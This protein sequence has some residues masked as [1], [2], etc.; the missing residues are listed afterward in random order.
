MHMGTVNIG[1]TMSLDGFINDRNG[2]V[3]LLY[4][5]WEA[6][7]DAALMQE[8]IANAGAVVMGRH[9]FDMAGDPDSYAV[10][11]EYQ[12]PIFVVTH[13]PPAKHPKENDQLTFTFVTDGIE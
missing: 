2:S 1:I 7:H 9:M 11:Y 12:A 4:P 8:S 3:D 6:M 5:D 10:D 13:H